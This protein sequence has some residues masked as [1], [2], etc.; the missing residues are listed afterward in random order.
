MPP[1]RKLPALLLAAVALPAVALAQPARPVTLATPEVLHAV[2]QFYD[3]ERAAP[4]RAETIARQEFPG[5][6]REKVAFDGGRGSRVP[7]YLALPKAGRGPFPVVI[8]ID[9]VGG[10]KERWFQEEGWP[11][12]LL[13][14]RALLDS[15]FAVLA[16]DARYHGER[17]AENDFRAPQ[18]SARPFD[19]TMIVE[20]IIEHR[21][22]L[23]YLA[24][25]PELDTARVGVL[26][27]SMG[28]VMTFALAGLEPRVKVAVAGVTPIAPMHEAAAIPIAP[29]TFAGAIRRTPVLMLMGRTDGWYSV[30]E[31][32]QLFDLLPTP[33]KELVFYDVGHRLPPEYAAKAVGWLV[34]HLR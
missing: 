3:Y 16:L 25:R 22:A 1:I 31:A 29:Q 13:V 14:T 15:G 8:L 27:M 7:G 20:S 34:A 30:A 4:L 32:Q 2:S 26:G 19:R 21:R 10:T 24:T 11:R 6:T 5:Y 12:G 23:D 18:F 17:A 33:R 9:G 28:G